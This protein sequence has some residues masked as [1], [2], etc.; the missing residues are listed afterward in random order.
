MFTS[1]GDLIIAARD[2]MPDPCRSIIPPIFSATA[3]TASSN[4]IF[5]AGQATYIKVTALNQWGETTSGTEVL[6]AAPT[7][8]STSYDISITATNDDY[9]VTAYRVY[10]GTIAGNETRYIEI[11]VGL[12][13]DPGG[14][15]G[16]T[17]GG[18]MI[19]GLQLPI[20]S[21]YP[22]DISRAWLPDTD[23]DI[24]SAEA[25][26]R[27]LRDGLKLIGDRT[28]GIR[29]VTGFPATFGQAQYPIIG[30]WQHIDNNFYDGYP[31]IAGRKQQVFR[32]SRVTGLSGMT[33]VNVS[34]NRQFVEM[35][36]QPQRSGGSS[37]LA[38]ALPASSVPLPSITVNNTSGWVLTFGLA[39]IGQYPPTRDYNGLNSTNNSGS[40]E[41]VYYNYVNG[42]TIG[43]VQRGM[44]GTQPQAWPIG[45]PVQEC[46]IY[47]TGLRTPQ[48]YY[49]GQ[50]ALT[51]S[52]PPGFEEASQKYLLH[53]FR[54]AEQNTQEAQSLYEAFEKVCSDNMASKQFNGPRQVQITGEGGVEVAA[55]LG[56]PFGRV[57][58]P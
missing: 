13:P 6:V 38:A 5:P 20:Q 55:G 32:R 8:P 31:V 41:L 40:C 4:L 3:V 28:G 44:G 24:I 57:I 51:F 46:N 30:H 49:R 52:C 37:T 43:Q 10:F 34:S 26:Y 58:V 48:M 1:V 2:L 9:S 45:T 53:R 47:M 14:F 21:G 50:S 54:L 11:P 7:A 42:S 18:A 56:S 25:L 15:S 35:W 23:G 19:S 29:D 16:L 27:W 36:P 33:T 17:M 39:V 22:P 12:L